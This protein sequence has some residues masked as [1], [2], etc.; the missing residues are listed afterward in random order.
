MN[1]S[2]ATTEDLKAFAAFFRIVKNYMKMKELLITLIICLASVSVNGQLKIGNITVNDSIG[3]LYLLDCHKH[4]DTVKVKRMWE[5]YSGMS[6]YS[7]TYEQERQEKLFVESFN[8]PILKYNI[9]RI[10][11]TSRYAAHIDTVYN[12]DTTGLFF[13]MSSNPDDKIKDIARR[14]KSGIKEIKQVPYREYTYP[15]DRYLI[16]RTPSEQDFV[17]WFANK[18]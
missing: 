10:I 13:I 11:D 17:K 7:Y 1:L 9:G 2:K 18:K 3:K 16:P 12:A 4:P 14:K 8:A 6:S 15:S 5:Q